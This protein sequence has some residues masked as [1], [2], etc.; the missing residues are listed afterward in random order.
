MNSYNETYEYIREVLRDN[1]ESIM[2]NL[3]ENKETLI[4]KIFTVEIKQLPSKKKYF[5][6]DVKTQI[7]LSD[8]HVKELKELQLKKWASKK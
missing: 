5:Q 2:F 3:Y 1:L 7:T 6:F 8:E 4:Q